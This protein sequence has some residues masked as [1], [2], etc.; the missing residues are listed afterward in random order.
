MYF[1][2]QSIICAPLGIGI[3]ELE[4]TSVIRP[5]RTMT[6]AFGKSRAEWPQSPTSMTVPPVKASGVEPRT[7]GGTDGW[8]CDKAIVLAKAAPAIPTKALRKGRIRKQVC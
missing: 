6:T 1:P 2:V 3:A 4:P 7:L 5:S 8:P